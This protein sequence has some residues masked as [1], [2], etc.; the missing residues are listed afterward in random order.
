M[1][2]LKEL[3]EGWTDEQI[4]QATACVAEWDSQDRQIRAWSS[5]IAVR[6]PEG[7][8]F[9]VKPDLIEPHDAEGILEVRDI[10]RM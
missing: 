6:Y 3:V 5:P 4:A 7:W 9:M 2:A 10:R 1:G 8:T